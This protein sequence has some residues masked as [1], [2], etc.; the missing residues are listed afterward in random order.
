MLSL[1]F[2]SWKTTWYLLQ[3]S[4]LLQIWDIPISRNTYRCKKNAL[5]WD[6]KMSA[7]FWRGGIK[8]FVRLS[9]LITQGYHRKRI[10]N[11]CDSQATGSGT[12]DFDW[13]ESDVEDDGEVI[14]SKV[15]WTVQG[16]NLF[17]MKIVDRTLHLNKYWRSMIP[18][19]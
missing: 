12:L 5:P 1:Y 16:R 18:Q 9:S 13:P 4:I 15:R 7:I 3:I 14:V 19:T 8:N 10:N 11:I 17:Q 2:C 6:T